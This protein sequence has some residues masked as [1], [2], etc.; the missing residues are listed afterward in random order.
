MSLALVKWNSAN[1]W[2]KSKLYSIQGRLHNL[3]GPVQNKNAGPLVKNLGK[4]CYKGA[5][6]ESFFFKNI[7]L[8]VKHNRNN[9]T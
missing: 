6:R 4:K 2:Q 8:V 9:N 5:K 7:L 1:F 3:Q